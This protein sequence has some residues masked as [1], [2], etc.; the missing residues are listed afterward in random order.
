SVEVHAVAGSWPEPD[1]AALRGLAG[2]V[3]RIPDG[4]VAL[5]DGLV[6]ST[7]PEVLVPEAARLRMVALVHM[8]LGSGAVDDPARGRERAVLSTAACAVTTSRWAR[9]ALI[10]MYGL[11][12]DRVHVAE[13]GVDPAEPAPGTPSG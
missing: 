5:L 13:P 7:A 11:P 12:P 10:D 3:A 8:P 1:A 6:A 4:A 2:A 9:E